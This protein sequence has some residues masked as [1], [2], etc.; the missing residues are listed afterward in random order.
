MTKTIKTF[1]E[2]QTDDIKKIGK[3][4]YEGDNGFTHFIC[5]TATANIEEILLRSILKCFGDDYRILAAE[6]FYL[7]DDDVQI[8]FKT[9]FPWALYREL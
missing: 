4:I 5:D 7:D 1:V 2:V 8:E 6:D 9:N 3:A